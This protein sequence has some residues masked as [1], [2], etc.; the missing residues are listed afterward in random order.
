MST[1]YKSGIPSQSGLIVRDTLLERVSSV[2]DYPL[3]MLSAPSGCGKTALAIQVAERAPSDVLWLTVSHHEQELSVFLG[4]LL[5]QL[6]KHVSGILSLQSLIRQ[7]PENLVI[8]MSAYL[9]DYLIQPLLIVID[10]W[11][12]LSTPDSDRWLNLCVNEFPDNCHLM[13]LS[14]HVPQLDKMIELIAHRKLLRV[15]QQDLYFTRA[16][17]YMLA[18]QRQTG[19]LDVDYIES[20]WETLSGWPVGTVLALQPDT[21]WQDTHTPD[22][23][24]DSMSEALFQS[25]ASQMMDQELPDMQ[26]FLKWTSTG[27]YFNQELC[28]SVFALSD[29]PAMLSELVRRNLFVSQ[30]A[31]GFHYHRLF[32]NFLQANFQ[33]TQPDDF[34][35]AHRRLAGWY[36]SNNQSN[37][38][39]E[40][41]F[42]AGD[43]P[44][45]IQ[46]IEQVV[47]AYFAQGRIG[48]ILRIS[49]ELDGYQ[50]QTPNLNAVRAM[51]YLGH[52]RDLDLSLHYAQ[53]ALDYFQAY[54]LPDQYDVL[55]TIGRIYQMQ[56]KLDESAEVFEKVL[57]HDNLPPAQRGL[58]LNQLG[59]THFYRGQMQDAIEHHKQSLV[60]IEQTSSVFSLAKVY[61]ELELVHRAIGN[62]EEANDCLQKQIYY[63]RKLNNPDQLAMALNN[64][65]YRCY[66][67]GHYADAEGAFKQ[68]L[69]T[70]ANMQTARSR[71]YLLTSLGDLQ[72]DKGDFSLARTSYQRAINLIAGREPYAHIEVLIGLSVLYRWQSKYES[73]L[74]CVNDAI[75]SAR[76]H[77]LDGQLIRAYIAQWHIRLRPWSIR[78]IQAEMKALEADYPNLTAHPPIDY[79]TLQ[80][81]IAI[82]QSSMTQLHSILQRLQQMNRR[83]ESIQ[84]FITEL[85]HSP[86]MQ[87]HWDKI[88]KPYH[89][90]D[91]AFQQRTQ[92][93]AQDSN[94]V[95]MVS[96]THSLHVY[97]LGVER[98]RKNSDYIKLPNFNSERAREVLYYFVFSGS[99]QRDRLE[100]ILWDDKDD[101]ARR[102]NFHQTLAR[103]RGALGAHIIIFDPANDLYRLNPDIQL[104]CDALHL[105]SLV[106][107]ARHL[108]HRNQHAYRLWYQ[109][110]QISQGDFLPTL[111]RPWIT[112]KRQYFHNLNIEAWTGL[113][114]YHRHHQDYR[115]ALSAYETIASFAPYHEAAYRARMECYNILGETASI[116]ETYQT[117]VTRLKHELQANPSPQSVR[118]YQQLVSN[119]S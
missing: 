46:L 5:K 105:E 101:E 108:S 107:E 89:E 116:I 81:H 109:A 57:L 12:L 111:S 72:R 30:R 27:D 38:A 77:K 15:P 45:A 83:G 100:S 58:I 114:E 17:L 14:Q 48:T 47:Y 49:E 8:E 68:G 42:I 98:I 39:L 13:I 37:Q 71:Y 7:S 19:E 106:S 29:S 62:V 33:L 53:L 21:Y 6:D 11:H 61:Q 87:S 9:R 93:P 43:Y 52:Q 95:S 25:I 79:L 80:L 76:E 20:I 82:L 40:H 10:D 32:H 99:T 34:R 70:I 97:T 75:D 1:V 50:D 94:I 88:K 51:I 110:T 18:T 24:T 90:L 74:T 54:D 85:I 2:L 60:Y 102:D 119:A 16:E 36:E 4:T 28:E 31:G 66:E 65:G 44:S 22:K 69:E 118:L 3:T 113:A 86:N 112:H 64:L 115:S 35:S 26:T 96:D 73:A 78:E 55:A 103:I 56:G 92:T 63:W 67:D 84:F 41:Y 23:Q 117:L 91:K 59:M 104:W